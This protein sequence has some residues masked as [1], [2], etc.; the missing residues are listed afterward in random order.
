MWPCRKVVAMLWF[1]R[2]QEEFKPPA[3]CSAGMNL[4]SMK[5]PNYSCNEPLG[6][7]YRPLEPLALATVKPLALATVK[8]LSCAAVRTWICIADP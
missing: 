3:R 8:P 7:D 6:T 5:R 2:G 4:L 1:Q